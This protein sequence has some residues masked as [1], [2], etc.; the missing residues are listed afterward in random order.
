MKRDLIVLTAHGRGQ[1]LCAQLEKTEYNFQVIDVSA[2]LGD[3]TVEDRLGPFGYFKDPMFD[4]SD[5]KWLHSRSEKQEQGFAIWTDQGLFESHGM[6][7][8]HQWDQMSMPVLQEMLTSLMS[9][10]DD[11]CLPPLITETRLQSAYYVPTIDEDPSEKTILIDVDEV[12]EFSVNGH[13]KTFTFS[14]R[15]EEA[16]VLANFLT[17]A[18][19]THLF[20][21]TSSDLLFAE[22]LEAK[23]AWLRS[24]V[25]VDSLLNLSEIPLQ[26]LFIRNT[27]HPWI[28]DNAWV[29]KR[30]GGEGVFSVWV[31]TWYSVSRDL[32]DLQWLGNS[33][34][35]ALE[36]YFPHSKVTMTEPLFNDTTAHKP[37]MYPIFDRDEWELQK[38]FVETGVIFG[39]PEK[40]RSYSLHDRFEHE[41][42][43]LDLV[44]G[45]L[46]ESNGGE[47]AH[48]L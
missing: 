39:G 24:T 28:E 4:M 10:I 7:A 9:V 40:W 34:C 45:E 29:L 13:I 16:G 1:W 33:V 32:R 30:H 20:P 3:R 18:E 44:K 27:S 6:L 42:N 35:A 25:K 46:G 11:P 19:I 15:I 47:L 26:T 23:A 22:P 48:R 38:K 21:F 5:E 36:E 37:P 17:S 31:K 2:K 14:D 8:K 12:I 43:V 41:K